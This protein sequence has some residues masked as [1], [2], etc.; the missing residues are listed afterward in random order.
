MSEGQRK[1]WQVLARK[2]T[3]RGSLA[4]ELAA[5]EV[6]WSTVI[7]EIRAYKDRPWRAVDFL[8]ATLE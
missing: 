8:G 6:K 1:H 3:S 7:R 4:Q 2:I 5:R